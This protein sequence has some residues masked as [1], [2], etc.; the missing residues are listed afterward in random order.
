MGKPMPPAISYAS[1]MT[2]Y[3]AVRGGIL[4]LATWSP[5]NSGGANDHFIF[6][7]DQLLASVFGRVAVGEG[8]RCGGGI[9]QAV[10]RRRERELLLRLVQCA[11]VQQSRESADQQRANGGDDRSRGRVRFDSANDLRRGR[12]AYGTANGGAL[13][14]Q[15]PAGNGDANL[16]PGEFMPLSIAALKDENADGKFDRLDPT[17]DFVIAQITRD[18]PGLTTITWNSVPEKLIRLKAAIS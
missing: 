7:T 5:G 3:A 14:A 9:E 6:V 13:V 18:A 12:C 2:I 10:Y 15:G 8:G 4:Y 17:R 11:G 16:D 1:G